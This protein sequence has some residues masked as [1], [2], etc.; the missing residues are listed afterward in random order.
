MSF[1]NNNKKLIKEFI[2]DIGNYCI[3]KSTIVEE[4]SDDILKM[5]YQDIKISSDFVSLLYSNSMVKMNIKK[6]NSLRELPKSELM[7]GDFM[8]SHIKD[9][10]LYNIQGYMKINVKISRLEVNIYY[11]I[12]NKTDFNNLEKIKDDVREAIKIVKFCSLYTNLSLLKSINIFLYLTESKKKLPTNTTIVLNSTHCNSAV[13]YACQTNGRLMIYR[14]EEWKKVLVH[15]LFHSFCLDFSNAKY[16]TLQK[17]VK[18]IFNV[19]SD[20]EI[21]ESYS[22][23]WAEIINCSFI[24]YNLLDDENDVDNFLLF[25]NFCIQLEKMFSLFQMVKM[26]NFMG[27]RYTNLYNKDGTGLR[28]I[29]YKEDTNVLCYYV[30]KNILL[31]FYDDFFEWC[32]LNNTNVLKFD[33][34]N[35]NFD[36]FYDFFKEKYDSNVFDE[37]I[38][39]M[40]IF[41]KKKKTPKSILNT[42]RMTMCEN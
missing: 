26:L 8:P 23:F 28:Q 11:G 12:F 17:R 5:I 6:I 15:E 7:N 1:T 31:F 27:L 22:E 4:K 37:S 20:F 21:S 36:R 38:N 30:I 40:E 14:K 16:T 41:F 9:D 10:I 35:D 19:Q 13:T 33:K 18:K 34:T 29:L 24:G 2:R 32:L 3:K 42:S 39:K 25:T